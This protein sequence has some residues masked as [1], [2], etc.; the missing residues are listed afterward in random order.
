MFGNIICIIYLIISKK[1]YQY[2]EKEYYEKSL[3]REIIKYSIPLVSNA[4]SWWIVNASDRLII[5]Y[6]I[7]VNANGIYSAANKFSGLITTIYSV[8]NLTWTESAAI[9]INGKDKDEYFSK[10]FNITIRFFGAL[11]LGIIA[12]MP[13]IFSI[14]INEKFIEAYEQIPILMMAAVFN[15]L[16]SFIRS[17]IYCQ[18]NNQRNSKNFNYVSY[19]KYFN[20]HSIN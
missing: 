6:M 15:A 3:L 8:F 2:I 7:N 19:N 18:K 12:F 10:I 17:H 13:F 9:N 5:T 1:I 11:C 14:M 20:K 16:V 4:I